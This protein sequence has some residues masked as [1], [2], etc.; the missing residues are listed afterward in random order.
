MGLCMSLMTN[1]NGKRKLLFINNND[2]EKLETFE[3]E[4]NILQ[5]GYYCIF[6][7]WTKKDFKQYKAK[8][9]IEKEQ[10]VIAFINK[11]KIELDYKKIN[12]I[13]RYYLSAERGSISIQFHDSKPI[14]FSNIDNPDN[15][16]FVIDDMLGYNTQRFIEIKKIIFDNLVKFD[17]ENIIAGGAST[18]I[19]SYDA[20][21]LAQQI[22]NKKEID[23][24]TVKYLLETTV[25]NSFET[26][27]D[28]YFAEK[29]LPQVLRVINKN[30]DFHNTTM[31]NNISYE[32][33][34]KI[35]ID[36]LSSLMGRI[37]KCLVD[38]ISKTIAV[39]DYKTG[40]FKFD[41]KKV[42]LGL[43]LQ[44]PIYAL[45][46]GCE[47]P[48]YIIAG[49][50]IQNV[51][52]DKDNV[53]DTDAYLLD[54]IT[55]NDLNII[56]LID[57]SLGSIYDEAGKRCPASIYIKG[58]KTKDSGELYSSSPVVDSDELSYLLDLTKK[59]IE[60][61]LKGIREA[62]F[63]ISPIDI[64]EEVGNACT[65]CKFADICNHDYNDTR[66]VS[67]KERME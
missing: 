3:H 13:K 52:L 27:K 64:K 31:L 22:Y 46:L 60:N 17:P 4:N 1:Y 19:F 43:N 5:E 18:D 44:L 35:E 24:I 54:G 15:I 42:E 41:K 14:Y 67:L 45:L 57:P 63:N 6:S 21:V 66:Y 53:K 55:L 49:V 28:R 12:S 62:R 34:I 51:L 7:K 25:L 29:L 40:K 9:Y 48:E 47:F 30:N 39:V 11:K 20:K 2:K 65:Y 61:T 23:V 8:L 26:Y 16:I 56:K 58:I 10:F 50:Y 36:E 59:H 33:E 37:D 32:K 38:D